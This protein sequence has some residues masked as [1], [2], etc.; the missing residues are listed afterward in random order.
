MTPIEVVGAVIVRA[1][2]VL[3]AKRS[4]TRRMPGRWEFPGGKVEI[5]ESLEAALEREIREELDCRVLVGAKVV[6]AVHEYDFGKIRLTTFYA[7]LVDGLPSATEHEELR[8]VDPALLHQLQ[9]APADLPTVDL[10]F[11]ELGA[12]SSAG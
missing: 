5:G 11:R 4:T 12:P 1:G 7:D 3:C 2:Q 6:T 10:V 9:W 8:W